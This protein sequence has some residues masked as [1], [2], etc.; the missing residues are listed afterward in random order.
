MTL[1]LVGLGW[2]AGLVAV[3][4]WQAPWWMAGAWVAAIAP[5]ALMHGP[6]K[7]NYALLAACLA[8]ALV[9]GWR[10]D[11]AATD[12][13]PR[14]ISAIG[15]EVTI[16]G[17]VD[18]EPDRNRIT[19]GYVVRVG[20]IDGLSAGGGKVLVQ[21][22]QY[23]QYLPGD[24]MVVSGELELPPVF[25]SFDYRGYLER[26]GIYATM[27][28]PR[29]LESEDGG[30]SFGRTL[31][32]WRLA[33]DR[34]LQ[35]SLPEPESSL[36]AGIAFGRDDGLSREDLEAYNRSGLRH[37]VAV[38]GSNVA[39]VS[40]MT[41]FL[42]IP[43]IGR[44]WAWIPAAVTI[45]AYLCAAGLSGSVLR[46]GIMAG[47]FLAGTVIGRPQSGLPALAAAVIAMTAIKPEL[48]FDAGFQLSASATAGLIT[49]SPWLS[50]WFMTI[51]ARSRWLAAPRVACQVAGLT[52]AA[53]IATAPIM[54]VTFS[55]VSLVSPVA[56]MIVE[57]VFAVAFVLSLATAGLGLVSPSVAEFF[58]MFAY[59]PLAFIG[60]CS[61]TFG[62]PGWA[63]F[64]IPGSSVELALTA[65]TVL[66]AVAF[67]AYRYRPKA[68]QES[69]VVQARR[70]RNWRL[71]LVASAGATF[72]AA[73]PISLTPNRGPGELRIDFLD[74]GQGDAALITTPHGHQLLID[75]GP[76]AIQLAREL[77]EVMPHWDRSLDVVLLTHPQ[78]D[79]LGGL[80]EIGA[81]YNVARV[82]DAG[83][84]NGTASFGFF[85]GEFPRRKV[86]SAGDSFVVDGVLFEILW[87]TGGYADDS[88]NNLSLVIRVTF[89]GP[90]VLFTGD[91]EGPALE[92]L[93]SHHD[94]R[95]DVLKVPHHGSKTTPAW[96]FEDVGAAVAV[97]SAGADNIF[98]HPHSATLAALDGSRILRTDTQGRVTVR[99]KEG[100]IAITRER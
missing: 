4:A 60:W 100:A 17:I 28:R 81:R 78:E 86:V 8:A 99:I 91:A 53:S 2:V 77:G 35:R 44:R 25:D 62:G 5:I 85:E 31:T 61:K 43:L 47:V 57:P 58:A 56:N 16:K 39:L 33:L 92:L 55:E 50:H 80:A 27:F 18:S 49:L 10:L 26:Q 94:L 48:A 74:V 79:H 21:L 20:S 84:T 29:V 12:S 7:A 63:T 73:V 68:E 45:A 32:K 46:A 1:V 83:T 98:G 65:Y 14:W 19:T 52:L 23:D 93:A 69:R 30:F 87:P 64:G 97:I 66:S 40:A 42:A 6:L 15:S 75:G 88:L 82:I 72:L 37:L 89:E 54:W 36:A 70:A 3:G 13:T 51:T 95:A 59:Y 41:Y 38:S 71:V 9:A 22:H 96:F 11:S 90:T 24:R 67:A 34:S 76:S